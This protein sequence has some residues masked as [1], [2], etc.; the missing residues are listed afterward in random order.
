MDV[1][2]FRLVIAND[3]FEWIPL[4]SQNSNLR[5]DR[6]SS[7]F[8]CVFHGCFPQGEDKSN[9]A[10]LL[11]ISSE[12]PFQ[13]LFLLSESFANTHDTVTTSV[14]FCDSIDHHLGS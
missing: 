2:P 13:Q 7:F 4:E 6:T 11:V 8:P 9:T 1:K 10:N 12:N 14:K 5:R 3:F